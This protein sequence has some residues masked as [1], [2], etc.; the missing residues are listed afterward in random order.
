M[1]I[2]ESVIKNLYAKSGN[3][4]AFP[5]CNYQLTI[6]KNQ[7]QMAHIISSKPNGPRHIPNYNNGNYD[8]ENNIILLCPNHHVEIDSNPEKFPCEMLIKMKRNHEE[9]VQNKLKPTSY[10]QTFI[11]NFISICLKNHIESLLTKTIMYYPFNVNLFQYKYDCCMELND[12]LKQPETVNVEGNTLNDLYE[13]NNKLNYLYQNIAC[14]TYPNDSNPNIATFCTNIP[15]EI[16]NELENT[17]K[18]LIDT[19]SKYRFYLQ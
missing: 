7:S 8:V 3:M 13:F 17:R 10:T 6:E 9:F 14:C 11:N 18:W 5:N 1:S 12:L 19:Y 16:I 15:N 4:C 2:P